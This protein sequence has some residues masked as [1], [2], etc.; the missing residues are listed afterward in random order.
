[1]VACNRKYI[2]ITIYRLVYTVYTHHSNTILS[3]INTFYFLAVIDTDRISAYTAC[4][5]DVMYEEEIAMK[6]HV[7]CEWSR[8]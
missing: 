4:L 2:D 5:A 1:M 7:M 3:A 6:W 8:P